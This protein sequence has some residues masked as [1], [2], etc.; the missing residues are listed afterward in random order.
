MRFRLFSIAACF[1]LACSFTPSL[2]FAQQPASQSTPSTANIPRTITLDDAIKVAIARN[3]T[4]QIAHNSTRTQELVATA[5]KDYMWLPTVNASGSWG[6]SYSL[7]PVSQEVPV[8]P[9]IPVVTPNG[10]TAY[11]FNPN[12][13]YVPVTPPAGSQSLSYSVSAGLY[14]FHG[15]AD[16][17][18][19]NVAE[20]ALGADKN[21]DT[22]TR[23]MAADNVTQA[24]LN[25]LLDNEL[26]NAAD[27]TLSEALAQLSLVK[28]QYDAGVVP[29]VQYYQQDAAVG[30]DSLALIQAVNNYKNAKIALLLTLNIP[31][32]QFNSYTFTADGIDTSTSA[33]SRAAVDTS[34][35]SSRF[36]AAIDKRP[37]IIAQQQT[38]DASKYTVDATRDALYPSLKASVSVGGGGTNQTI[39]DIHFAN[40]FNAG[41]T[42]SIPIFDAMQTRLAIEEDEITVETQQL[43]LQSD[44]QT[45]RSQAATAVNNLQSASE[46]LDA[47]DAALR[48][49]QEGLRLAEEQLSVGSGTEVSVVV[50][51]ATLETARTS[52]V[53]AK[54]N[55]V[56]AQRQL[57][58]ILGKW[59]Y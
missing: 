28:G 33:A 40:A 52:R 29:I 57:D 30:Q 53:N 22:W 48:S 54:Y 46:A 6:Y 15:G 11:A 59:N 37:D 10:D 24:Y 39:S 44:V 5:A 8:D 18:Q 12:P 58:Y 3:Y 35:S 41:L 9:Y 7:N 1:I 4:V 25:V 49:A 47:S 20:S 34:I 31:P 56:F 2:S 45:V 17:A 32:E 26:V 13:T 16:A 21:N 38:I 23:Q 42:L 14:L 55:W 50:A 27:S 36:N 51:E 43:Q 19:V